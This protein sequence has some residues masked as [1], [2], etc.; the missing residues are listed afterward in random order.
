MSSR[1]GHESGTQQKLFDDIKAAQDCA[2]NRV[3][4]ENR[5]RRANTIMQTEEAGRFEL[6]HNGWSVL[7]V[8]HA[9]MQCRQNRQRHRE[10]KN[11]VDDYDTSAKPPSR[12]M[13]Q[14]KR[15]DV[16]ERENPAV[17]E[18]QKE[19]DEF[20]AVPVRSEDRAEQIRN[21]HSGKTEA[22]AAVQKGFEHDRAGKSPQQPTAPVH[23]STLPARLTVTQRE[24]RVDQ[25]EV[26]ESLGKIAQRVACFRVD[27]FGEKTDVVGV[28]ERCFENFARFAQISAAGQEVD[29]PKTANR[30]GTFMSTFAM[31]VAIN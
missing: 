14:L 28:G 27:F 9:R 3:R 1:F 29:F 13:Q 21:V 17:R 31:V 19:A 8:G 4:K 6:A 24:R 2:K 26:R 12:P 18:M 22:L 30:K 20:S 10:H 7:F 23:C 25:A 5:N 15:D 11:A 16:D